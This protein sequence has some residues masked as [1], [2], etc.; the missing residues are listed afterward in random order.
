MDRVTCVIKTFERPHR[1]IRLIESIRKYYP[2]VPILVVDDSEQP[3]TCGDATI[4]A[5]PFNSGISK[6]R[7]IG[8]ASASTEF[9]LL[10]DDDYVFCEATKIERLVAILDENPDLS[11][12][13][14]HVENGRSNEFSTCYRDGSLILDP[15]PVSSRNGFDIYDVTENFFLGRRAD[16]LKSPWDERLPVCFEHTDFF[17]GLK[18]AGRKVACCRAVE[19]IEPKGENPEKYKRLRAEKNDPEFLRIMNQYLH[20]KHGTNVWYRIVK[21]ELR[22]VR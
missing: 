13:A 11:L 15:Q 3:L 5:L 16:L 21:G 2:S 4:I 8:V 1:C 22:R 6:G 10:M 12:C 19:I 14:G 18:K 20:A 9:V 7:N 17:L